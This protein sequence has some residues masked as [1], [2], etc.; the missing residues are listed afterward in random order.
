MKD[1]VEEFKISL[2]RMRK[3]RHV[4]LIPGVEYVKECEGQ[5]TCPLDELEK[6]LNNGNHFLGFAIF[7]RE[8][9]QKTAKQLTEEILANQDQDIFIYKEERPDFDSI[10]T[11]KRVK[12]HNGRKRKTEQ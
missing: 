9:C 12:N 6:V 10:I 3:K 5:Y 7:T 1:D 8:K 11:I 2:V 4:D